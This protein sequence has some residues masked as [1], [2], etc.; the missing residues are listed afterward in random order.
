MLPI[1]N[2]PIGYTRSLD[3]K[4]ELPSHLVQLKKFERAFQVKVVPIRVLSMPIK[5]IMGR[6][7]YSL[8]MATDAS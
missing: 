1:G 2:T 8:R 6:A 7:R 4:S 3:T 5:R